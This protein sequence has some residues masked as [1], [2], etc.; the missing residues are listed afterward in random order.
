MDT[1]T[2]QGFKCAQ[3]EEKR[4]NSGYSFNVEA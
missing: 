3:N 4:A 2:T 1:C